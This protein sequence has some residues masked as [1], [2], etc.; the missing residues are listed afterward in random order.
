MTHHRLE[1]LLLGIFTGLATLQAQEGLDR[2]TARLDSITN[3]RATFSYFVTLPITDS[4]IEYRARLDYRREPADTLCGYSYLI[5][6][7]A[8]NDTCPYPNFAAYSRGNCFHFDRNRLREYHYESNPEPFARHGNYPGVHCSGLFAELFPA[9]IAHQLR[10][11]R[12]RADCRVQFFP[13]TLVQGARCD[14]ILVTDSVR[15]EVARTLLYTFAPDGLPLY[16]ETENNPGHLGSQTVIVRYESSNAHT[17]FPPDHFDESHLLQDYGEV[18]R[19]YR[20]GDFAARDRV[21]QMAPPFSLPWGE[22]RFASTQLKGQPALLL[23]LDN[24]GE[25]C[26]PVRRM[27]EALSLQE[28]FTPV[29][30]YADQQPASTPNPAGAIVLGEAAKTA[31]AYGVTGFP[32]LFLLD[33]EGII[34]YVKVGYTPSLTEEVQQ[35]IRQIQA[36]HTHRPPQ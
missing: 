19:L 21:G 32:T 18:F 6:Y 10:E 36:T 26:T 13:D 7:K 16:R 17:P 31:G 33:P 11:Y 34:R 4:D 22:R 9:E 24:W 35:A 30:L 12:Q 23:F 25:F 27:A 20:E 28:G 8:E 14:A 29:F 1:I 5:D 15:G 2:I 3:Y